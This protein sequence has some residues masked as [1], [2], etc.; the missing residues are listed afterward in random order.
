MRKKIA[1]RDW[2]YFPLFYEPCLVF[3]QNQWWSVHYPLHW[4]TAASTVLRNTFC[5]PSCQD[6]S[7]KCDDVGRWS[8]WKLET[9]C[10]AQG[11]LHIE[12]FKTFYWP[13]KASRCVAPAGPAN[14]I[15]GRFTR[16]D[17]ARPCWVPRTSPAV[18]VLKPK[19]QM[20]TFSFNS[21]HSVAYLL[22]GQLPKM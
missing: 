22:A 2:S 18:H 12:Y 4:D 15:S 11:H 17:H 20:N 6:G 21:T 13:N 19:E 9:K 3:Y 5:L 16:T 1:Y 8:L 14:S 10:P 7:C